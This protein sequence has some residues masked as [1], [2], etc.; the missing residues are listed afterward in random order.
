MLLDGFGEGAEDDAGFVQ[1]GL[2]GGGHGNAIE[3]RIHRDAG[4][5][6]L[7]LQGDAELGVGLEQL[8]IDV[9][10]ALG[11]IALGLGG[12]IVN[13]VLVVDL[14][15]VDVGPIGL[16][17]GQPVVVSLETPFQ[18]P[19]RLVFLGGNQ[20]DHIFA[21][22]AGDGIGFDIGDETPLIFLIRK[23]L[24]GVGRIAHR[25]CS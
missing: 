7:L 21:Q 24:D 1:L 15:V 4:Q 18:Q 17:E 12:R 22:A 16:F 11:P 14:G 23:G 6:G 5:D 9:V 20:A 25:L 3:H 13:N 19:F 2:E 10:Q 8:R